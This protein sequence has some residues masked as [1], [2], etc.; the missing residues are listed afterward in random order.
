M[1]M[2]ILM[3]ASLAVTSHAHNAAAAFAPSNSGVRVPDTAP[4]RASSS[5]ESVDEL[6]GLATKLNPVVGYWDPLDF[7]NL[8]GTEK[9]QSV[10]SQPTKSARW[11]PSGEAWRGFLRHAELKHGRVA[12]AAFVGYCVQANHIHF[13]WVSDSLAVGSPPEQ[14]DA[15]PTEQKLA[16]F[17]SVLLLEHLGESSDLLEQSGTKHYMRGGKPGAYPA[18]SKVSLYD[19]I[20]GRNIKGIPVDLFDPIG[21]Q[22]KMTP[23]AKERARLVEI[24]NG[25][26]AMLGI[27]GFMAES[28]VQGSVPLLSSIVKPYSGEIMAPFSQTDAGLPFVT[29][30]LE[31]FPNI[32]EVAKVR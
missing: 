13:P 15:L 11:E 12:M 18:L 20:T 3:L 9:Y 19:P 26:L 6:G 29:Q 21:L 16:V 30:M 25:R 10:F 23:E 8:A 14:W 32:Y 28:K 24:N 1:N 22:R 2:I 7:A 5:M 4:A 31:G 17:A 27:F